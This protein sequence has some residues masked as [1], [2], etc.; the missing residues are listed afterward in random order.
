[1]KLLN[2]LFVLVIFLLSCNFI[3]DKP[4]TENLKECLLNELS[5]KAIME[6]FDQQDGLVRE[7]DG[8]KYYECYFNAEIKFIANKDF[9]SAGERY[10]I[11]NGTLSFMKTERGWNC[12]D[13]D[14]SSSNF[15]KIKA[16]GEKADHIDGDV[17]KQPAIN[18]GMNDGAIK[19]RYPEGSIKM[20]VAS[21]LANINKEELKIMRNEIYARHGY[22]F[23]T[24]DMKNYFNRQSWYLP[25]FD[26]VENL[27][28]PTEKSN[29]IF[30]KKF[31]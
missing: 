12:Q 25:Q 6:E 13:F 7:K 14:W 23:K 30:I 20:L 22:I 24:D 8:V 9:Y 31:E 21:D 16:E 11:I 3:S 4:S 18:S 17:N 26:N 28:T 2:L 1:M 29:V 5:N 19:G 27:L 15:V 10:K